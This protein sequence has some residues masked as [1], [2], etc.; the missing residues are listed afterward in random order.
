MPSFR[1]RALDSSGGL[2]T[3][4]VVA[5]NPTEVARH[6]ESLGL[7]PI[8][9]E[10]DAADSPASLR[11]FT[12]KR[13][14]PAD[15]T[16]L[17]RDL[18]MLLKAG[19]R[20]HDGLGLMAEDIDIGPLKRVIDAIRT[21]IMSGES[22]A[23]AL[24]SFPAMFP[25]DYVALVRIGEKSGALE[26]T[27]EVLAAERARSEAFHRRISDA[28]RYP[29][30]VLVASGGVLMF[31]LLFVLPQFGN[32]LRDFGAEIDPFARFFL[33]MSDALRENGDVVAGTLLVLL[34]G[35]ALA[36]SRAGMRVR[37]RAAAGRL[38]G[39][40][41][42]FSFRRT[43]LF[44]RNLG[45]LLSS[46]VPLPSAL[47]ILSDMMT[48]GRAPEVTR[49]LQRVREGGKLSEAL[50]DSDLLP[51]MAV[52]MIRIGE[53]TGQLPMLA[54]RIAD[55][56]ESRLERSLERVVGIIGPLA[57]I[58]ISLVVGGLIVSIMTSLLSVTQV[59]G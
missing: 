29:A 47:R 43:A 3:G 18:A 50:T 20:L 42:V 58:V 56:Y 19:T 44:T 8:D 35:V 27:L 26:G 11:S 4:S 59:I 46:G 15:V 45:V 12:L 1:Y 13:V 37:F 55:L 10:P 22:F 51:V 32:V 53:E 23:D 14:R 21:E 24:S 30:F 28:L 54:A 34:L 5:A 49:I 17:T 2:V 52:R 38:P 9:S 48:D 39:L 6:V 36:A 7:V 16:A 40:R 57:I 33:T 41:D 31:F 25:D